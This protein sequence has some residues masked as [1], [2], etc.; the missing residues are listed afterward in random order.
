MDH[1]RWCLKFLKSFLVQ[2]E[3]T[4]GGLALMWSDEVYLDVESS[5]KDFIDLSCKDPESGHIMRITSIHASTNFQERLF[6]WQQIHNTHPG[7][8]FPWICMGDFNEILYNW[9]KIGRRE[10]DHY[11]LVTFRDFQNACSLMDVDSKGYAFTWANKALFKERLDR[12]LCT[13]EWRI[14][15]PN[16]EVLDL[17]AIGPD[18]SPLLL[19]LHPV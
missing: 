11:R 2:P 17:L 15:F 4:T 6:L 18:H 13:M 16:A 8:Q 10:A 9:E 1:I 5:S 19:S 14:L 7:N 3:G 12:V